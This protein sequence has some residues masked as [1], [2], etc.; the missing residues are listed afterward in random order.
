MRILHVY[1]DYYPPV[2]GGIEN[3]LNL[4]CNGLKKRGV[5]V[6]V[7]VAN[8]QMKFDTENFNGIPIAKATQWGR[9][10][11]APLTPTFHR[12]LRRL[13]ENADIIHFHHPNPTAE[14]AYFFSNLTNKKLVITYHS[15]I[16]RQDKLGKLYAPFRKRFLQMAD[17]IIATSPNYIDSSAVL[18]PL[19]DRCRVIPLGIDIQRFDVQHDIGRVEA[20]R[21]RHA[22]KPIVLFVGCFRYYKGLHL[23]IAAMKKVD[24]KLLL[25]GNG[26]ESHRLQKLVKRNQLNNKIEFL[27]ELSDDAVNA[28]YKACDIFVLP[29]HLRSEAFGLVQLEA[30]C[31][32]KPVIST[33]L[34]T[35]TSF[36]NVDQETGLTVKPNDVEALSTAINQLISDPEKRRRLGEAGY[37]RVGQ[38]FSLEKMV[39][40]TLALYQ[41]LLPPPKKKVLHIITRLIVGGAQ[42]NTIYTA[43]LL[44]KKDYQVDVLSGPQTGPEGS[45][46]DHTR[47]KGIPLTIEKNLVRELNPLKD[48]ITFFRL[49][50]FIKKGD[51]A[52]VH[53]HSSKAG[54]LGRWAAWFAGVPTIVHT[55]HGWGFHD[56]QHPIVRYLFTLIEK[57]TLRIS[58]QLIAVTTMDIEKGVR[59]GIGE[60]KTYSLIRSGID[61]RQ[62]TAMN[63]MGKPIRA[64]LDIPRHARVIGTVTRLSPQ[65]APIIFINAAKSVIDELPDTYFVL[66]GDGPMKSRIEMAAKAHKIDRQ[67]ILTGIRTDVHDIMHAFD[68]FMLTSLWEG[69]PRVI[70]Q[71]IASGVPVI[72]SRV[73]GNAE[74][75]RHNTTGLLVTPGNASEF[76]EAA[77][78]LIQNR[79]KARWMRDNAMK[80]IDEYSVHT[81]VQK[82]DRLYKALN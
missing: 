26:P 58:D 68:I 45:L 82:I 74:I 38:M 37:K 1:K 70:P 32:R 59:A 30:M 41:S 11:S 40:S 81:M 48:A 78:D 31:C 46:I 5:G 55:V 18:R 47:K 67:I 14:F 60:R 28:Y 63:N 33:E 29:S 80:G 35:G 19:K 24:A 50:S 72:A 69:L 20:I 53:T 2:K 76:A 52:I 3:H 13:G 10:S 23:L 27:G 34:G 17:K 39:D 22:G 36:V 8:T 16:I 56:F 54:I 43:D 25:I 64:E 77:M 6:H 65:K 51:Y 12:Y 71:A 9:F 57:I 79:E 49:I 21:R 42:E 73:D 66:V 7:L 4:L 15:D 61:L 75:I 44:D 62:F